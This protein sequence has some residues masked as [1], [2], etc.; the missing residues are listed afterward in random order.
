[1]SSLKK[2][3]ASFFISLFLWVTGWT[4]IDWILNSSYYTQM[5]SPLWLLQ[6]PFTRIEIVVSP[7][8]AYFM[9]II[10]IHFAAVLMIYSIISLKSA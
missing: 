10:Q 2:S 3:L 8:Q 7:W 6:L 1:M 5:T 9:S 4:C